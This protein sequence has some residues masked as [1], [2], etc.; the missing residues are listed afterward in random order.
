MYNLKVILSGNI[1]IEYVY[2]NTIM[3]VLKYLGHIIQ[4][5]R[6]ETV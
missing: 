6:L 4:S 1:F 2:S 3:K 5:N